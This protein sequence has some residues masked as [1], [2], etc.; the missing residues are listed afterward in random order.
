MDTDVTET[1]MFSTQ[2]SSG[3]TDPSAQ[4]P[5]PRAFVVMGVAGSGKTTVAALLAGRLGASFAEGDDFHSPANVAKMAAGHPLDDDDRWP[6]LQ[7]IRDWFAKELAAGRSAVVPCSALRR[8]YRD[9]LETA[10]NGSA[11][12]AG[13]IGTVQFVHL[14]GSY[15]LLRT[16]IQGRAGHF[17]KPEMLDSQLAALEPLAD[18][19]PGFAVDITPRPEQI[20]DEI[21]HRLGEDH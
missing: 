10:G 5:G 3:G 13:A 6:W 7:G 20:V 18:D 1:A 8:S 11:D 21:L 15:E 17:M 14:T 2:T 19:E 9:L 16:R 4:D 12:G